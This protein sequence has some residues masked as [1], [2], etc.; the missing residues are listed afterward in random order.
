MVEEEGDATPRAPASSDALGKLAASVDR[1]GSGSGQ[2]DLLA[3]PDWVTDRPPPPV[4]LWHPKHCGD[5]GMEIRSDGS[6]WH[7]GSPIRR[8]ELVRLFASILRLEPDGY[9]LV[10]PVEKVVVHVALH[11]LRVIDAEPLRAHDPETLVLTLNTGGTVPLDERHGLTAEPRAGDAAF[12]TLDNGLTALFTRAAW[13]R[14]V[15]QADGDGCIF[16]AGRRVS[17]LP[18]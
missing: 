8:E 10:T 3:G 4:H 16:S 6:W 15:E 17:L 13:Y 2:H 11:P 18:T 5:I 1:G 14:L 7:A 9:F 12:I